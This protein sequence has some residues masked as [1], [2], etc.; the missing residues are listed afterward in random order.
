MPTLT[1][2]GIA[3]P[4]P[5][6][7]IL[8]EDGGGNN[9]DD[10]HGREQARSQGA[11]IIGL[12]VMMCASLMT[13]ASFVSAMVV[14]RGLNSSDWRHLHVPSIL[15]WNTIAILV[16]SVVLDLA[17]RRFKRGIA[18]EA[19]RLQ[20]VRLWTAGTALGT[21]FLIG[22]CVA[23]K[24]LADSG[25]YLERNPSSAFFYVLTWTHAAHVVGAL[26]AVGYVQY[27][28]WRGELT[29]ARRNWVSVSTI[30]WHFLDI[31]WLGIMALFVWWA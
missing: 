26:F 14:R 11:A 21:W 12:F 10:H 30:F 6:D 9:N 13:F 28:V 27:R 19:E 17:R 4:P 29:P 1:D 16:S 8:P 31:L 25:F 3:P 15:W 20:F 18:A 7:P 24:Q 2:S 5:I 23:W 22:Q